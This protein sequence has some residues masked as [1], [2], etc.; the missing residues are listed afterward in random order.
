MTDADGAAT[1]RTVYPG[2]Y[3]GRA[4]HI[5]VKVHVGTEETHTGQLFFEDDVTDAVYESQPYSARGGPDIRNADDGIF[6]ETQGTTV[7]TVTPG[8]DTY[9]GVVTLGVERA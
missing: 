3:T 5:H 1:F 2:W 9:S 6:A 7:V 4:V 8:G